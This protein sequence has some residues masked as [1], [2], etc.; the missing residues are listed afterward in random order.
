MVWW[1]NGLW[2]F[3][4]L[5]WWAVWDGWWS[6]AVVGLDLGVAYWL[7]INLLIDLTNDNGSPDIWYT[8]LTSG[9]NNLEHGL[10]IVTESFSLL[11]LDYTTSLVKVQIRNDM[12]NHTNPDT[13]YLPCTLNCVKL[14]WNSHNLNTMYSSPKCRVNLS[15]LVLVVGRSYIY[16]NNHLSE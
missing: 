10:A 6:L 11:D 13:V 1:S 4:V 7:T 2:E 16:Q 5:G 14:V 12:T 3:W 15:Q 8:S 9:H